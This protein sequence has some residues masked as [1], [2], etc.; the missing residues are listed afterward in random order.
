[1]PLPAP[2]GLRMAYDRD[3]TIGKIGAG[4]SVMPASQ[5]RA[6]NGE[7][8][9]AGIPD[10]YHAGS[11]GGGGS[12]V[13]ATL[14][15]PQPREVIGIWGVA[16]GAG[17]LVDWWYSTDTTNGAD[18]NWA[19]ANGNIPNQF[20]GWGMYA[21]GDWRNGIQ[22]GFGMPAHNITGVRFSIACDGASHIYSAWELAHVYGY[23]SGSSPLERLELWQPATAAV[24]PNVTD[25]GDMVAY[26]MSM[27]TM[28][29]HNRSAATTAVAPVVSID[30]ITDSTPQQ[31]SQ[32]MVS[33]DNSLFLRSL[34]LGDLAPGATSPLVYVRDAITQSGPSLGAYATRVV[35]VSPGIEGQQY[36]YDNVISRPTIIPALRR[37]QR[38][39]VAEANG[40]P[41]ITSQ[42]NRGTSRQSSVRVGSGSYW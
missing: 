13:C 41:R 8:G 22:T 33:V 24:L 18:G 15:F 28:R 5:L 11:I 2:P 26:Q 37:R 16:R 3:G 25:F 4:G 42:R 21:M 19:L 39:D 30:S 20:G 12:T 40:P 38:D 29:V 6:F 34:T 36:L 32:Y 17:V 23:P 35:A 7:A 1:M 14:V 10:V 9:D 27:A 31:S